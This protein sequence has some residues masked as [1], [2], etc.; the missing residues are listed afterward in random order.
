MDKSHVGTN[1]KIKITILIL[2]VALLL[3]V[4]Y[5]FTPNDRGGREVDHDTVCIRHLRGIHRWFVEYHKVTGT[6]LASIN[7][8]NG[9]LLSWRYILAKRKMAVTNMDIYYNW[10]LNEPWQD[11][12]NTETLAFPDFVCYAEAHTS[13][14][15]KICDTSYLMLVH[16]EHSVFNLPDRAVI[17]IESSD[18]GIHWME[19]KDINV[20]T[21]RKVDTPFGKGLLNSYHDGYIYALCKNGDIIRIYKNLPKDQV[22][23]ILEG[24]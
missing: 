8:E 10:D 6:Y 23:A 11:S 15:R 9:R 14:Q 12:F 7:L 4:A 16:S 5:L 3:L 1:T 17:V 13:V 2:T 24:K 18:S 20:E 22:I 21:L 19:P